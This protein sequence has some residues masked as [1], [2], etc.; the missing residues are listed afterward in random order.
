MFGDILGCDKGGSLLSSLWVEASDAAKR[1]SYRL[2]DNHHNREL[3]SINNYQRVSIVPR[4]GDR[5]HMQVLQSEEQAAQKIR[6]SPQDV[7]GQ[8]C[9]YLRVRNVQADKVGHP[10]EPSLSQ[11]GPLPLLCAGACTGSG[12]LLAELLSQKSRRSGGNQT[13]TPEQNRPQA[14]PGFVKPETLYTFGVSL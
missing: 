10:A 13:E 14:E 1:T 12:Q 6:S 7:T 5:L 8:E 9:C 3:S 11:R 4:L 2:Q